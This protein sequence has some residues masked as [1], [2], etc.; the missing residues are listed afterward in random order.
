MV[1]AALSVVLPL[2]L[3][4]PLERHIAVNVQ[5]TGPAG[6]VASLPLSVRGGVTASYGTTDAVGRA[7]LEVKCKAPSRASSFRRAWVHRPTARPTRSMTHGAQR[8]SP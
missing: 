4:Q 3:Q 6:A 8:S 1:I 7:V 5:V 2:L